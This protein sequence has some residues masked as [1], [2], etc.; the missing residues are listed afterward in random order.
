MITIEQMRK[1]LEI[2]ESFEQRSDEW[3]AARMGVIT[4]S[5]FKRL[6]G[7]R[8]GDITYMSELIAQ[9]LT[10][11]S[12]EHFTSASMEHGIETENQAVSHYEF[13]NDID[14]KHVAFMKIDEFLGC[15]PDGLVG[16]DGLLEIK[17]P[18]THTHVKW[19]LAGGVP[20]DHI[21]QVLGSMLVTGRKWVDFIS[22]DPRLDS[23]NDFFIK[24]VWAKDMTKEMDLLESKILAF[25]TSMIEQLKRFESDAA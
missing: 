14:V 5:Q 21:H 6:V 23:P 20:K 1:N 4:A 16:D 13:M 22:F 17:C 19:T 25:R 15:S 9:K 12:K 7:G 18:D 24:R 11:T 3:Y 10:G 2:F 8:G